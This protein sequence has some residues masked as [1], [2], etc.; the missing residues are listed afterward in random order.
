MDDPEVQAYLRGLQQEVQQVIEEGSK[1]M[2][3][4]T[5]AAALLAEEDIETQDVTLPEWQVGGQ[6]VQF[7]LRVLSMEEVMKATDDA[8]VITI[9]K[10]KQVSYVDQVIMSKRLV[11]LAVV[12][13]ALSREDVDKLFKKKATKVAVLVKAINAI[14][15]LG[16]EDAVTEAADRFQDGDGRNGVQPALLELA[17][18][19]AGSGVEAPHAL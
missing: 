2:G 10:G 3:I 16:K 17:D 19:A 12:S 6:P 1:L 15:D 7:T 11:R 4:Q 9:D 18:G 14:N 5:T 13:P 8:T